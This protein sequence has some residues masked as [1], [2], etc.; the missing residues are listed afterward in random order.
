MKFGKEFASQLVQ[1]WQGAYMDYNHLKKQLKII[2][3]SKQHNSGVRPKRKPTLY[4]AF[5]GLTGWSSP[6]VKEEE[7]VIKIPYNA[8]VL[9][10]SE[11]GAEHELQFFKTLDHE[12][13]KV[14]LFHELKVQEMKENAEQLSKQM[15]ALIAL[16]IRV[17]K[18]TDVDAVSIDSGAMRSPV[19]VASADSGDQGEFFLLPD[20][21][22][23][24]LV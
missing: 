23:R 5:S 8:L 2:D 16:R 22:S 10:L 18:P 19:V 21:F 11:E 12:F 15:D 17:T 6:K 14:R 20:S 1:E 13:D 24:N 3:K 4:R 9:R 7:G